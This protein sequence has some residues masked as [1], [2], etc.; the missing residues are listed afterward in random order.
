MVKSLFVLKKQGVPTGMPCFY[1]IRAFAYSYAI[2]FFNLPANKVVPKPNKA[3]SANDQRKLDA[4][5]INPITGGPKRKP[6][7]LMVET[8][9]NAN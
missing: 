7:K 4:W 2:I 5:A 1:K 8:D 6:T 3:I 9:A